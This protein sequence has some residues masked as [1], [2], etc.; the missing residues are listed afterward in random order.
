MTCA[1]LSEAA[2]GSPLHAMIER[3]AA[4]STVLS[5]A[6]PLGMNPAVVANDAALVARVGRLHGAASPWRAV[7]ESLKPWLAVRALVWVAAPPVYFTPSILPP[8]PLFGRD[9]AAARTRLVG[10]VADAVCRNAGLPITHGEVIR[11]YARILDL[12]GSRPGPWA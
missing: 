11:I 2:S 1:A 4:I 8:R 3:H 9:T 12:R 6:S 7:L 10:Y 5:L